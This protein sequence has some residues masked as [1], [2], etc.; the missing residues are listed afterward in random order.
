MLSG[1]FMCQLLLLLL[2]LLSDKLVTT[3]MVR[4]N[5]GCSPWNQGL[6]QRSIQKPSQA[7]QAG[8]AISGIMAAAPLSVCVWGGK[9]VGGGGGEEEE[10]GRAWVRPWRILSAWTMRCFN[11]TVLPC[12][13]SG[14][15]AA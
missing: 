2:P 4:A 13:L 12:V 8:Q 1:T 9:G 10:G 15:L 11:C 3:R 14:P 5:P 7:C 6:P